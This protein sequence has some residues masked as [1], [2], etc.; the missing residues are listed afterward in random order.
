MLHRREFWVP[1]S[2]SCALLVL[3]GPSCTP[4]ER[5][6]DLGLSPAAGGDTGNDP[7]A[8]GSD[9]LAGFSG[10]A[11]EENAFGQA[12]DS[13]VAG[14]AVIG[15][16]GRPSQSSGGA[17]AGQGNDAGADNAA[18]SAGAP[19]SGPCGDIDHDEVDDCSETLVQNSGFDS[20]V[21]HW[22]FGEWN[23]NNAQTKAP[24]G[25][26]LVVN[27][28]PVLAE[29][30]LRMTAAEQCVQV[31]GDLEYTV[32]VRVKIP[33]GQGGGY[34]GINLW[35]FANDECKGTFV[36]G[37]TPSATQAI[38]TWTV[39]GTQFKMPTAARSMVV[40]LAAS[41]PFAQ[42]KLQVLFDDILVK[43]KLP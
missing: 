23:P 2:L 1:A 11:G 4:D 19:F 7:S 32:L 43:Q 20:N 40:R 3:S 31:T 10:S 35:I 39:V 42:P 24:S 28:S 8:A 22:K 13:G 27:D 16:G 14:A 38:D 25:S 26:L 17:A 6:L 15:G 30:G 34:G 41:R 37:L 5:S 36:T 21:E 33:A 18:G 9:S 12:G 29:D